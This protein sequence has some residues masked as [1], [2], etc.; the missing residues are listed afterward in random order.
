LPAVEFFKLEARKSASAEKEAKFETN[1]QIQKLKNKSFHF[2]A[3]KHPKN[4]FGFGDTQ[5]I[6]KTNLKK[7]TNPPGK[8]L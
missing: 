5:T 8:N 3:S 1:R 6:K 7:A 4:Y 2:S